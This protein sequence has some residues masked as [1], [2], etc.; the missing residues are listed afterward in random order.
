LFDWIPA[1][2]GMTI[3]NNR[4]LVKLILVP[5]EGRQLFDNAGDFKKKGKPWNKR[6]VLNLF[7][8]V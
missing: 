1:F 3:K 5:R 4:R 7:K 6:L 8:P 2:A